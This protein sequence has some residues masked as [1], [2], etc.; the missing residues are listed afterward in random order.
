MNFQCKFCS[1]GS[2]NEWLY[3]KECRYFTVVV[4]KVRLALCLPLLHY[5]CSQLL[6]DKKYLVGVC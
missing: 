1:D 2:V 4:L 5:I 3:C 6:N